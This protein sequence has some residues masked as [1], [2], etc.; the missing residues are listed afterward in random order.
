MQGVARD[1]SSACDPKG[2][3]GVSFSTLQRQWGVRPK[4]TKQMGL[5][6]VNAAE[7]KNRPNHLWNM[8]NFHQPDTGGAAISAHDRRR[9][10][11]R[12]CFHQRGFRVVTRR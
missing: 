5:T 4:S 8:I 6:K 2:N 11:W 9:G 10:S 7:K 1:A 3:M 12:D